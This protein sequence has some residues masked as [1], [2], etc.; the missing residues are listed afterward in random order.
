MDNFDTTLSTTQSSIKNSQF[1][2]LNINFQVFF[3]SSGLAIIFSCLVLTFP[4][5]SN[6]F[7]SDTRGFVVSR[8]D[9]LFTVS[10]SAFTIII[11]FLIISPYGKIRLG[12]N[13]ASP[14]F[15]F[16]S[17][18]CMLFAAGVGIG[19]T[20]YGAAEPLSYYTGVFGTPL[21]V[22]PET[23]EAYRLAFSA[24]IFHWGING[25]SVYAMIGLSLA[26][27]S[28]NWKL[29]L[30]IRSIFYPL[31]GNKIWGWQGDLIDIIAVLSTLFGLATSLGLGAQQASSGLLYLFDIPNNLLSQTLV[32]IF[33]TSVAIFSVFRGL[34]KGV[35]V[36]SNINIGLASL[37]LVFVI[38][39]GPTYQIITSYGENL[40][41]YFQDIT[42]LSN[43]N[44][45]EDQQ[46]YRDWTIFYWAWWISWSP[47]VGMFIARI[48]KG[49]TIREFLS[50]AMFVPLMF[51]LIWFSSFGQTA[52]FQFQE[53]IGELSKPV[54]D[55]SLVLF[56]MLDNLLL[57]T[58]T[59]LFALL[60]LVLFFVTSSDSGSLVINTITSGGKDNTPRIQRVIWAVIQGLIAVV[61][62]VGGGSYALS[63]IQSGA[64]SMAL[65]FVFVLIVATLSLLRGIYIETYDPKKKE[66]IYD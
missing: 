28:Y 41:F 22:V 57:P 29:P 54:T 40:L 12:G 17:W 52:I 50:A 19:M 33:I 18:V 8:F 43:W 31:L 36:L 42:R 27:F 44:R 47:F 46:W 7:L 15:S 58:V 48:S 51:S 30:T 56:Y 1:L 25:W 14:E 4:E 53:G 20:F 55:I 6:Q 66:D 59:S 60:M 16:I 26:F 13:N 65:P 2:G 10:M 39:A 21:N 61:L 9:T 63:A 35:K 3:I 45:P 49:R 5:I 37:L 23:E 11:F 64:I 34:D 38:L 24:T 62:L 32:I